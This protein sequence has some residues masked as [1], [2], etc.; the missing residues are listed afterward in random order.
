[1]GRCRSP[2]VRSVRPATVDPTIRPRVSVVV[3]CFNH[4]RFLRESVASA[5][6]QVGVDVDV[7]IL[8]DASEDGS[9]I[10]AKELAASDDRVRAICH[11]QNQGHIATFNEGISTIEGDYV[12]LLS[13]DDRLTEGSL[14]RATALLEACPE[15]GFV[16]GQAAR[17]RGDPPGG[18]GEVTGWSVWP[19]RAWMDEAYGRAA[20]IVAAPTVVVR[21]SL[22]R[23]VGRY[24]T[25]LPHTADLEMWLRIAGVAAVG[26]V[27]GT[28][29]A[30]WRE[31]ESNLSRTF[32]DLANLQ[33]L[34]AAFDL[35]LGDEATGEWASPLGEIVRRRLA[36]HALARALRAHLRGAPEATVDDLVAFAFTVWPDAAGLAAWPR[37]RVL[38]RVPEPLGRLGYGAARRLRDAVLV[39]PGA[40]RRSDLL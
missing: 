17:W 26:R 27:N 40:R 3:P 19:A 1:M 29:Q 36:E 30:L 33:Q 11:D 37:L 38:R 32:D 9:R 12:V 6:E 14:G 15:V 8:D 2:D 20:N 13:A 16:Y 31:H 23:Q 18:P 5:L 28:V 25:D 24:R 10:L 21:T 39:L 22:Q 35:T 34:A 4:S 7:L